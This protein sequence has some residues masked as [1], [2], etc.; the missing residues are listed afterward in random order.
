MLQANRS[1]AGLW[2][3]ASERA[4]PCQAAVPAASQAYLI[5]PYSQRAADAICKGYA[6]RPPNGLKQRLAAKVETPHSEGKRDPS[7]AHGH[8]A[9]RVCRPGGGVMRQRVDRPV[10]AD[11]CSIRECVSGS[12]SSGIVLVRYLAFWRA[13]PRAQAILCS[14]STA[15]RR[16]GYYVEH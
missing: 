8:R 1:L 11:V 10:G 16:W 4:R 15:H 6:S 3:A 2:P 7:S 9:A 12:R 14:V 13:K 5:T